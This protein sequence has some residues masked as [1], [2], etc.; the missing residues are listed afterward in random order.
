MGGGTVQLALQGSQDV[1]LTGSPSVTYFKSIYRRHSSFSSESVQ[2]QFQGPA[3]FGYISTCPISRVVD[4]VNTVWLEVTLPSLRDFRFGDPM[5]ATTDTPGI[6]YAR[7]T[8]SSTA[9]ISVDLPTVALTA[10]S[11]KF[12]RYRATVTPAGGSPQYTMSAEDSGIISVTGLSKGTVY[13]VTVRREQVTTSTGIVYGSPGPESAS[14]TIESLRWCNSIG[15]AI[16]NSI[17][18]N[19]GGARIDRH[20]GEYMDILAELTIPEEKLAGFN[21][22]IGKYASYDLYDNSFDTARVL[23]IPIQFTFCKSPGMSLPLISLQFHDVKLNF[24]F[25]DYTEVIKSTTTVTSLTHLDTGR[26]PSMTPI[27]Y[28]DFVYLET[29]E[30]RRFAST[31]SEYLIDVCQFLGDAPIIFD[32]S[33][34]N[35]TRKISV[36]FSHPVK[37]VI[38]VYN[39]AATYNSSIPAS[40]YATLGNDYTNCD[41]PG[42]L[43]SEDPIVNARL[44]LNGHDRYSSRSGAY[45]RLVQPFQCHTRVPTKKIYLY[46][47]ALHPEDHQP[48]GTCN[49]SRVDTAHLVVDLN[50]AMI[51]GSPRGRIRVFANS[52]QVLRVASGMAGLAFASG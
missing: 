41:L 37:E 44:Q 25:R 45:H 40:Q 47:F 46:S 9:E 18:L 10:I 26:T 14:M 33:N 3:D 15:H 38:W 39:S 1:L 34:P 31:P 49:F 16:F 21:T 2:Q 30:R 22:M 4:L 35:A 28:A 17:E 32:A 27:V 7:W 36:N 51:T 8:S 48:S 19:V 24:D 43:A 29:E 42:I 50:P 12:V 6:R 13:T 20:V 11:G 23:Y 5:P 52:F